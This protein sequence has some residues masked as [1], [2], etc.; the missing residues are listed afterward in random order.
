MEFYKDDSSET[1]VHACLHVSGFLL[2]LE[3]S[4][5][6]ILEISDMNQA[7]RLKDVY[8]HVVIAFRI[9]LC[10]PS[11]NYATERSLPVLQRPKNYLCL[12][13]SENC[14][15]SLSTLILNQN[16]QDLLTAQMSL[17]LCCSQI[18]E[19]AVLSIQQPIL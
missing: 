11:S 9:F 16:S 8:L 14:F 13:T 19:E 4:P 6:S 15:Y 2:S 7:K 5:T 17:T 1:F 10:M 12:V 18:S 3:K